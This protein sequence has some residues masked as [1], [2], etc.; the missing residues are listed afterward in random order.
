MHLTAPLAVPESVEVARTVVREYPSQSVARA[1]T[2]SDMSLA[3][4]SLRCVMRATARVFTPSA[5]VAVRGAALLRRPS[6]HAVFTARRA[7]PLYSSR[8]Q[9]TTMAAIPGTDVVSSS[10]MLEAGYTYLDVRSEGEFA[11]GHVEGAINVPILFMSPGGMTPNPDFV[12]Q[13]AAAIPDKECQLLLGCKS[14][15][16]SQLAGEALGTEG[17]TDMTN[18]DGGFDAWAA[19]GLPSVQ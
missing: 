12:A 3:P 14:G 6:S 16:R 11:A 9:L 10:G 5:R 8:R 4:A 19:K 17:Y 1:P 13:V 7:L 18:V 2:G 15:K